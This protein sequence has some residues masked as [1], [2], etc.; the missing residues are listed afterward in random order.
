M[1]SGWEKTKS[2]LFGMNYPKR[3]ITAV[4]SLPYQTFY[5]E[6]KDGIRLEGWYVPKREAKGTVILFHGHGGN[7]SGVVSEAE[8]FYNFGY[9]VCMADFRAHGNSEGNTCTIG[10]KESEDVKAIYDYV[11]AK[12]E[13]NIILYG[14]SLG[15][16]T[17]TK[18][19]TDHKE[20]KPSKVILEMPF[21]SLT[22]AVKGRLR[23]MHLPAQPF[24]ALLT[25]W[26]GT[27]HGF[28]AFEHNPEEYAANIH[29]PVLLQ[30][31]QNDAR[32]TDEETKTVFNN[33]ASKQ[34]RLVVYEQSGHQS[35]LN[36]EPQK[37][38][39]SVKRFLEKT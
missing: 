6:T 26:G 7:K 32:V 15:A 12:G 23:I 20:I 33:L 11:T 17:I 16:A 8:A 36:N 5:T 19:I 21:A 38:M 18:A 10:Y 34:K 30:W 13:K 22:E 27:E 29:V 1:Q 31:G 24:A 37:W 9:N 28:W 39:S 35:L 25:F 3:R 4:P 2:I 14:I